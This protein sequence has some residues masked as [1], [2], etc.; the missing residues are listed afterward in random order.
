MLEAEAS[1]GDTWSHSSS[2][3]IPPRLIHAGFSGETWLAAFDGALNRQSK[4][5]LLLNTSNSDTFMVVAQI[6]NKEVALECSDKSFR[7]EG[8]SEKTNL[9]QII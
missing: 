2:T 3:L 5:S 7:E 6:V 9:V 8:Y 1:T 4:Y